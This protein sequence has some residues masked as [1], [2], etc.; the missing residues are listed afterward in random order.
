MSHLI[1]VI[2]CLILISCF[3][4]QVNTNIE[5]TKNHSNE[6]IY[7]EKGL[8]KPIKNQSTMCTSNYCDATM[9]AV[10]SLRDFDIMEP[11]VSIMEYKKLSFLYGLIDVLS[12]SQ[13]NDLCQ[14]ELLML[15]YGINSKEIWAV[16][17]KWS[18]FE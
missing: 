10:N 14:K 13:V 11:V 2:S 18:L 4:L 6:G 15:Q 8:I 7:N 12:H 16:K 9:I 3:I 5:I 17:G 1:T